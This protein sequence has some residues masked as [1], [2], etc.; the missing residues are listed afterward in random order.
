MHKNNIYKTLK[1]LLENLNKG[2]KTVTKK[3]LDE[4]FSTDEDCDFLK[5]ATHDI[6]KN[7]ESKSIICAVNNSDSY[8]IVVN[9]ATL[10]KIILNFYASEDVMPEYKRDEIRI[11]ELLN[12]EWVALKKEDEDDDGDE[13]DSDDDEIKEIADKRRL[14]LEQKRRELIERM[15]REIAEDEE[16]DDNS[17]EDDDGDDD[18]DEDDNNDDDGDDESNRSANNEIINGEKLILQ[19]IDSETLDE[20][21]DFKMMCILKRI[22]SG[23]KAV[24]EGNNLQISSFVEGVMISIVYGAEGDVYLTD[25]G[26]VLERLKQAKTG[27]LK[28]TQNEVEK[29]CAEHKIRKA[30]DVLSID[31]DLNNSFERY[32][33]FCVAIARIE[34]LSEA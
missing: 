28:K 3:E 19:L 18:G 27:K 2:K 22:K 14:Y 9:I 21:L 13:D 23:I 17:D 11:D 8:D 29:I 15:N 7:L 6:L 4:Y 30:G 5:V 25:N 1:L 26:E 32:C 34:K 12:L 33:N 24:R 20:P 31:I 16:D 10:R